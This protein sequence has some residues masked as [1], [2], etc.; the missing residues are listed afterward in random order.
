MQQTIEDTLARVLRLGEPVRLTVAGRTDAGVHASGQVAHVDVPPTV[1]ARERERVERRLAAVLPGDVRVRSVREAPV[2]F[3]ARFSAVSRRYEYRLCDRPSI[4]DP[5]RR[6]DTGW[7]RRQLDAGAMA[8][9]SERMVGVHDFAAYCKRREGATTIRRLLVYTWRRVADGLLV[10]EV[11]ADAFCHTMVRALVGAAVAVGEGRRPPDW[12][13]WVLRAAVR[14][15]A[16]TVMPAHGLALRE[17]RYP[18]DAELATRAAQARQLR[19]PIVS[20]P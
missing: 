19:G 10:A 17:V 5:V 14:D 4:A 20:S 12:P 15:P 7:H 11:E 16:V 9:A 2:G 6:N 3:D 1:W 13:Y 8:T 18:P